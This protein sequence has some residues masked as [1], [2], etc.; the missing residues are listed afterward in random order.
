MSNAG[1]R[2]AVSNT[3]GIV[4]HRAF[5]YDLFVWFASLGREHIY[6]EKVLDLARLKSCESVLDIGC[7]TVHSHASSSGRQ[8]ASAVCPRSAKGSE[9]RRT[10]DGRRFC[11]ASRGETGPP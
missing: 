11:T 9:A 1:E 6:R 2:S 5:L 8:R 3:T 4:I 7:G 10:G